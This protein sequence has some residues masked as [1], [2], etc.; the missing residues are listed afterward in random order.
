MVSSMGGNVR[1][2]K[3]GDVGDNGGMTCGAEVS[4]DVFM[5]RI[6][7]CMIFFNRILLIYIIVVIFIWRSVNIK[8]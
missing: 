5:Q 6:I 7:S 4:T 1:H 3:G 2:G 8:T